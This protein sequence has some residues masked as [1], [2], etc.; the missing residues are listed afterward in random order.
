MLRGKHRQKGELLGGGF[1]HEELS[2]YLVGNI[3]GL[4]FSIR[5]PFENCR[6]KIATR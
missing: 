1:T 3:S 5:Y 6:C 2:S 4:D